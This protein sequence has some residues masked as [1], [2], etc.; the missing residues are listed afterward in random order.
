MS[1]LLRVEKYGGSSLA[2]RDQ[3]QAIARRLVRLQ[4][5]GLHIVVVVSAQGDTT[6]LLLRKATELCAIP[7]SR[8][9]DMLI[10]A[11]ER[12]SMALLSM[13][14]FDAG[15]DSVS[16]TGSQ[17]GIITDTCHGR[18]QV[19]EVRPRRI[20]AALASGKI[21]VVAGYQGVSELGEI[22]SLGRG[23]SD[24]TAVVLAQSLGASEVY[25]Y[26][27]VAGVYSADPRFVGMAKPFKRLSY[28]QAL[29]MACSGASVLHEDSIRWAQRYGIVIRAQKTLDDGNSGTDISRDYAESWLQPAVVGMAPVWRLP[30][31]L[32]S[33]VEH[34]LIH[35]GATLWRSYH[36][37]EHLWNLRDSV[38]YPECASIPAA[39]G[40][41]LSTETMGTVL[42]C[43]GITDKSILPAGRTLELCHQALFAYHM[44]YP[45][46]EMKIQ[47]EKWHARI[48]HRKIAA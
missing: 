25:I 31:D 15:G 6:D 34:W 18:A 17:S 47:L 45:L 43:I 26:S 36:Q 3:V 11:G 48:Y 13:A 37:H 30:R 2:S 32:P 35:S 28:A 20:Q 9:L 40:A 8:E 44:W 39:F 22:T 5:E 7:P 14:I 12:I 16:F 41:F 24:T 19:V 42:T 23:G 27:D 1:P 21:V 46:A 38:W 4:R 29:Y 10:T 33:E